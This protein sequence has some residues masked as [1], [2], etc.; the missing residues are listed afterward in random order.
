MSIKISDF[1]IGK[2]YPPFIVAEIS[3]NHNQK[4]SRALDLVDAAAD[5]GVHALKLQTY[6]PD[7]ITL[8][9]RNKD[10]MIEGKDSLWSGENLYDLYEKAHT[11]WEWHKPIIEHAIKK[12]LICFSSP[13]DETAVDFLEELNMPAY[14]IASFENNHLPLIKKTAATGKP[15]IISTG[16]ASVEELSR[17]VRTAKESGCKELI[18]LKCT[19]TYPSSPNNTNLNTIPHIRDLFNC[20]VGLS[21]HTL[22]IGAAIG[23]VAL[24]ATIIEK[25]FTLSRNDGGVDSQFSLEPKEMKMLVEESK[26]VWQA[27]GKIFYGPSETEMQ[28]LSFRR[29]IFITKDIK[30]GEALNPN[31]IGIYRPNLGLSPDYF[32]IVI[33]RKT[34]RSLIAGTPLSFEDI[35]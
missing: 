12:G 20:E 26:R 29:S 9:V 2:N 10:F 24:G 31:N 19:S 5:C 11:P 27:I 4:L 8:N 30:K 15:L 16:M 14:K 6:T 28:S 33:G 22:G 1:K 21:D 23:A 3:G 18:L 7:T 25:H 17:A 35:N 13:F 34:R 32:D